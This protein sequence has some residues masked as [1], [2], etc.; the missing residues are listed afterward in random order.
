ML[1]VYAVQ[2]MHAWMQVCCVHKCIE[3]GVLIFF[4]LFAGYGIG[5]VDL[6]LS[7]V[8]IDSSYTFFLVMINLVAHV[9]FS[10]HECLTRVPS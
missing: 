2:T 5:N 4:D 8:I 9:L 3:Y 6:P 10:A 1:N 7:L